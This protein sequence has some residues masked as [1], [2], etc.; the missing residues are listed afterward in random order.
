MSY[1]PGAGVTGH[2]KGAENRI[3]VLL[4]NRAQ[5]SAGGAVCTLNHG[6]DSPIP[7]QSLQKLLP[8]LKITNIFLKKNRILGLREENIIKGYRHTCARSRGRP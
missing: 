1:S 3:W 4:G 6:A 2:Q 7:K 5:V 8:T